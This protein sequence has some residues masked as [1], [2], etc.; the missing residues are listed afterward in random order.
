MNTKEFLDLVEVVKKQL[1]K[2]DTVKSKMSAILAKA[3]LEEEDL[4]QNAD[5][6]FSVKQLIQGSKNVYAAI[7]TLDVEYERIDQY[8]CF[9]VEEEET[10]DMYFISLT[11][12]LYLENGCLS[13]F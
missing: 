11:E 9:K 2:E 6:G 4:P 13:M 12:V 5:L 8:I 1:A 10:E 3:G 7:Q